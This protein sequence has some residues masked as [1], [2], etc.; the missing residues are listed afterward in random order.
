MKNTVYIQINIKLRPVKMVFR[1]HF[2]MQDFLYRCV[3]KPRK[4]LKWREH[5]NVSNK[6][7]DAIARNAG[8]LSG[9]NVAAMPCGFLF[10]TPL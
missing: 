8:D 4:I 7:P 1:E 5:F 6:H 2:N 9:G 10:D 3:L